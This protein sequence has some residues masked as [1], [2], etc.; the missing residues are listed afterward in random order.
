M[1]VRRV[2]TALLAVP[3]GWLGGEPGPR[4]TDP[5]VVGALLQAGQGRTGAPGAVRH[6]Q[7]L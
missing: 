2:S 1:T 3:G 4:D 6:G 7:V 5:E